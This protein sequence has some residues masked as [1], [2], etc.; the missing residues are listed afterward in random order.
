MNFYVFGKVVKHCRVFDT[1]SHLKIKVGRKW[2][3]EIV[4]FM[5]RSDSTQSQSWFPSLTLVSFLVPIALSMLKP[6]NSN[7][8]NSSWEV[9][10]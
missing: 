3:K 1:P 8:L 9:V 10:I 5:L 6:F 2:R 7:S 4:K